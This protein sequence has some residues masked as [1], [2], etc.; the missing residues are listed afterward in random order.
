MW[1]LATSSAPEGYRVSVQVLAVLNTTLEW[2]TFALVQLDRA[3]RKGGHWKEVNVCGTKGVRTTKEEYSGLTRMYFRNG[4]KNPVGGT[5]IFG[6]FCLPLTV[7]LISLPSSEIDGLLFG[8]L[9]VPLK[10]MGWR[11]LE[12]AM[13]AA[14]VGRGLTAFVEVELMGKGIR[15]I[16]ERDRRGREGKVM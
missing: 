13:V 15:D 8:F 12:V 1:T 11:V 16:E 9:S 14:G 5:G 3:E 2:G 10:G 7:Y 4:F 6:L